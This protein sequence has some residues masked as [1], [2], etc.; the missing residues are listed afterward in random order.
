MKR[1]FVLV[2]LTLALFSV[3]TPSLAIS[4]R[5]FVAHPAPLLLQQSDGSYLRAPCLL[6]GKS[7]PNCRPDMGVLPGVGLVAKAKVVPR[8]AETALPVPRER[9]I[10][11]GLRPPR[12]G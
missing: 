7:V 5:G 9:S 2:A 4:S 1:I 11:P 8:H 6:T 10:A 12:A 3:V